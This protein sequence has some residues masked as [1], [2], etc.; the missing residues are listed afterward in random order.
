MEQIIGFIIPFL[1]FNNIMMLVLG[2]V[3]GLILGAKLSFKEIL[4][5]IGDILPQ[6]LTAEGSGLRDIGKKNLVVKELKRQLP[7]GKKAF[8]K[9]VM[10]GIGKGVQSV[11]D[12][13]ALPLFLKKLGL[14]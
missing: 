7:V 1:S 8:T 5:L 10:G 13:I 12:H 3:V 14:K 4:K 2:A 11:F 6:I 9:V